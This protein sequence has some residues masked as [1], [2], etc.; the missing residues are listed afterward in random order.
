MKGKLLLLLA[1]PAM[2]Y[3][4]AKLY[5]H[6]Q[7]GKTLDSVVAQMSPYAD[8]SYA[9]VSSTFDGRIGVGNVRIRPRFI[10]DEVR[11]EEVSFKLPSMMYLLDLETRVRQQNPP[12]E[13]SMRV[14]DVAL[15]THGKLVQ[16]WEARMFADDPES[17]VAALGNCVTRTRLPSQ[18]YLLDY[19]EIRGS[20]EVGYYYDLE[21][22]HF[23]VHGTA[24][25]I[26]AYQISGD[27]ALVMP[28]F[29][30]LALMTALSNPQIA[31]AGLQITDAGYFDRVFGYCARDDRVGKDDVIALL[32]N[33]LLKMFDAL[34]VRPDQPLLDAY[35]QFIAEG[36]KISITAEPPEP[37]RLQYLSLYAP[38]DVPALLN[39]R[40]RV[41]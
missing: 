14:T 19:D 25:Q 31:R 15:S 18:M 1:L 27:L 41:N 35:A 26:D 10:D 30:P 2:V 32:M 28:S 33:D 3:G 16:A 12:T 6:A 38:E 36:S 29:D 13:L 17:R 22:G 11:I 8:V 40:T 4:G 24:G 39:I 20:F 23:V 37:Q 5:L 9:S 7:V 34:P 21:R